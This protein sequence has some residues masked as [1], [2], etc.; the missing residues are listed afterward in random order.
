MIYVEICKEGT[1]VAIV[2]RGGDIIGT[3]RTNEG[4]KT[5]QWVRKSARPIPSF[6]TH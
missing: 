5:K 1:K 6:D 4:Y 2:M 3:N